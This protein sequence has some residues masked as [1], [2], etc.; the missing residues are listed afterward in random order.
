MSFTVHKTLFVEKQGSSFNWTVVLNRTS[1]DAKRKVILGDLAN[2]QTTAHAAIL[3][4]GQELWDIGYDWEDFTPAAGPLKTFTDDLPSQSTS[5][6]FVDDNWVSSP[7]ADN[8][9]NQKLYMRGVTRALYAI[10]DHLKG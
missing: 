1:D 5:M 10:L 4:R 8:I 3:L 9:T 7:S 6:T 2:N